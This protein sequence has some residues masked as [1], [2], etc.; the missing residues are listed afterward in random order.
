[1][2]GTATE[3]GVSFWGDEKILNLYFG[4]GCTAV[5]VLKIIESYVFNEHIS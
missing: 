4:G 5:N 1:M 2:G 3:H